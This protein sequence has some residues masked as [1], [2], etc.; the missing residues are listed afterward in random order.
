ML[1]KQIESS[2]CQYARNRGWKVY[3]FRS[4]NNRG[5]PDRIFITC[6]GQ[7]H[8]VEFKRRGGELTALQSRTISDLRSQGCNVHVIDDV[9]SGRKLIDEI[10]PQTEPG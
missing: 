8:F 3:K 2:V 4:V 7:V 5:V 1:E 9:E 10:H 6:G